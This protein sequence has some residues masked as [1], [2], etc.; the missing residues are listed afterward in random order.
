[1]PLTRGYQKMPVDLG[2]MEINDSDKI[3]ERWIVRALYIYKFLGVDG[4]I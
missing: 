1:M 2:V 4:D 3:L